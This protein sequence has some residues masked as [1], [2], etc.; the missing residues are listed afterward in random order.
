MTWRKRERNGRRKEKGRNKDTAG[1]IKVSRKIWRAKANEK[2][3]QQKITKKNNRRK[4][5]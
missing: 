3:R 4:K 1:I 5:S 2:G